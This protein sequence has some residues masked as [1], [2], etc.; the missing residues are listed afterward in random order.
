MSEDRKVEILR[1]SSWQE[2]NF[3]QL[4]VGDTFRLFELTGEPVVDHKGN[5]IFYAKSNPH[6]NSNNVPSIII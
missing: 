4:K 3:E 1:N 5:T 2:V 6:M